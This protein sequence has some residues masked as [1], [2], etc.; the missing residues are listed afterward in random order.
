MDGDLDWERHGF[1][2]AGLATGAD[3]SWI[4]LDYASDAAGRLVKT[5]STD[6]M[7]LGALPSAGAYGAA[8]NLNQVASVPGRSAMTWTAAG[9][10]QTNGLGWTY[11]HDGLNRL[12]RAVNGSTVIAMGYNTS[13]YRIEKVINPTGTND[14][15]MPVGGVRT[16]YLPSGSEE[17]ADLNAD[18]S[19]R[20]RFIPG[21]AIDERLAEVDGPTG[22][23][24]YL[25]TDR[26]SSM[27]AMTDASGNPVH[28][29]GYRA[30]RAYGPDGMIA[31]RS[32]AARN[33][34]RQGPLLKRPGNR[35][36]S[37]SLRARP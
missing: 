35:T 34:G 12:T 6:G 31:W 14:R 16:R 29:R 26:Q 17:V 19:V 23:V 30:Y 4:G 15:G 3:A 20:R 36:L 32:Y 1:A 9:N 24:R 28:R 8:N 10:M 37:T 33:S 22:A 18:L 7:V 11:T 5:A 2:G 25:H 21:P 13:G 27:I